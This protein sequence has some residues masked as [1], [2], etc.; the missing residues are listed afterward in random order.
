MSAAGRTITFCFAR[1]PTARNHSLWK[2]VEISCF[3]F[4][5]CVSL[6]W[7]NMWH[8][9]HTKRPVDASS[10]NVKSQGRFGFGDHVFLLWLM[11]CSN[12]MFLLVSQFPL[13]DFGASS[14]IKSPKVQ[15]LSRPTCIKLQTKQH[16]TN[17]NITQI[18]Q[19]F[20][21]GLQADEIRHRFGSPGT[22]PLT[23]TKRSP[24]M[25]PS[26]AMIVEL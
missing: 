23:E 1:I 11:A 8:A 3:F 26:E 25:G 6:F 16:Q 19:L 20:W 2:Q 17:Q 22:Q 7:K 14:R 5:L 10:R 4:S 12:R 24:H 15:T 13:V 21:G 18:F 9:L